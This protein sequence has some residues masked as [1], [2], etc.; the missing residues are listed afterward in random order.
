[1]VGAFASSTLGMSA[2]MSRPDN[3]H[4]PRITRPIPKTTVTN[5]RYRCTTDATDTVNNPK[6]V[7]TATNPAA[8]TTVAMTARAKA[9]DLPISAPGPRTTRAR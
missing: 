5:G 9:R 7:K 1:M 8:I 4:R 3:S 6:T 2:M